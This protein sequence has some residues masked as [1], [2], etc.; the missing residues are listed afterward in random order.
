MNNTALSKPSI[1]RTG[2]SSS[3]PLYSNPVPRQINGHTVSNNI[4]TSPTMALAQSTQASIQQE[5]LFKEEVKQQWAG[6]VI[7][8][9][10]ETFT[11]QLN[12]K[13]NPENPDEIITLDKEEVDQSE[14]SLI[15]LGALLYWHIGY[16]WS[17]KMSKERFSKIRFRRLPSWSKQE[18]DEAKLQAAKLEAFFA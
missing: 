8:I 17:A 3:I 14:Q 9:D 1:L 4:K 7:A 16:R 12:D 2:N 6:V 15:T 5:A 11:V 13:T 10:P 18:L